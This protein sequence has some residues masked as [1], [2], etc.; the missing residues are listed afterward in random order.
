ML[1]REFMWQ[2]GAVG[3]FASISG[4]AYGAEPLLLV[5]GAGDGK[6]IHSFTDS[7]LLAMPQITF[8]TTTIWTDGPLT[9]SGPSLSHLLE[10]AGAVNGAVN[11][12]AVNDY[13]VEMPRDRIEPN[14]PIIANRMNGAPFG[15]REKGPLWAVFPFDSSD[16]YKSEETYS[17][18]IWQLTQIRIVP[19]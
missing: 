8:T 14:A 2:A 10:V 5:D 18:S 13:K 17:Y 4:R 19:V 1:R 15:I 9:F 12:V 16:Y 11:M 3:L 6:H 7:D